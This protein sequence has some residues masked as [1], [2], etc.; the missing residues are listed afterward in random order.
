[1]SN[2]F[3][4][5]NRDLGSLDPFA[6]RDQFPTQGKRQNAYDEI[7][8]LTIQAESLKQEN[9]LLKLELLELVT[10]NPSDPYCALKRSLIEFG[11]RLTHRE[12]EVEEVRRHLLNGSTTTAPTFVEVDIQRDR[13]ASFDLV[14]TSLLVSNDQ[15]NFFTAADL[16][17]QNEELLALIENQEEGLRQITARLK[18]YTRYQR[19]NSI[20]LKLDSLRRGVSP[21]LLVDTAPDQI[22]E[23]RM[24]IRNLAKELKGLVAQRKELSGTRRRKR[25]KAKAEKRRLLNAMARKIQR[26]WRRARERR[27]LREVEHPIREP[28][29]RQIPVV[30]TPSEVAETVAAVSGFAI[31]EKPAVESVGE[32][33]AAQET[34]GENAEVET[35]EPAVAE[36]RAQEVVEETDGEKET[37]KEEKEGPRPDV[38]TDAAEE[39]GETPKVDGGSPIMTL[40]KL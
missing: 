29:P 9:E 4:Y 26:A 40:D 30:E 20:R 22:Q 7:A 32:I 38:T 14:A 27:R 11:V 19:N 36:E 35:P 6:C 16:R 37:E 39:I 1:M 12:K 5:G 24:K 18:L 13:R 25:T 17:R 10:V 8:K 3:H 21:A 34:S 15:R 28:P 31:E 23:Q 33:P 2:L